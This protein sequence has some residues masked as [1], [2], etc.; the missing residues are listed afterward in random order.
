MGGEIRTA[1]VAEIAR[2][3]PTAGAII[4]AHSES[5]AGKIWDA[6]QKERGLEICRRCTVFVVGLRAIHS[7][8]AAYDDIVAKVGVGD[9]AFQTPAAVTK[10]EGERDAELA[11]QRERLVR[12]AVVGSIILVQTLSDAFAYINLVRKLR[13]EDRGRIRVIHAPSKRAI[14]RVLDQV[15]DGQIVYR[16]AVHLAKVDLGLGQWVIWKGSRDL[17]GEFVASLPADRACIVVVESHDRALALSVLVQQR[18]VE[19][20][21]LVNFLVAPTR[22][23]EKLALTGQIMPVFYDPRLPERSDDLPAERPVEEPK[24]AEP[25]EAELALAAKKAAEVATGRRRAKLRTGK[26]RA[27]REEMRRFVDKLPDAGA[28]VVTPSH[29]YAK[30]IRDVIAKRRPEIQRLVAFQLPDGRPYERLVSVVLN[31]GCRTHVAPG[32]ADFCARRDKRLAKEAANVPSVGTTEAAPEDAYLAHAADYAVGGGYIGLRR[33]QPPK[34]IPPRPIYAPVPKPGELGHKPALVGKDQT[35][36]AARP[37]AIVEILRG[38]RS[39]LRPP[40]G[41]P[42][43]ATA[44][45]ALPM[46]WICPRC[47]AV[48]A[49]HVERCTCKAGP[50][51]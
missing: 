8:C 38:R 25:S 29:A 19:A 33:A 48:L 2:D 17:D 9:V 49:P 37:S 43:E 20:A 28:T 18:L 41:G 11:L 40:I 45:R 10:V 5:G 1:T 26:R 24:P 21:S 16:D 36:E 3:V 44:K 46:G 39:F 27:Q 12:D 35:V 23:V 13:P 47:D 50:S 34:P 15:A 32:V 6:L 30:H 31:S 7:V 22:A 51:T 4:M 42:V 14:D